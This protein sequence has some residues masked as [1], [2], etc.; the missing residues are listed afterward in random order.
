MKYK[1][2]T[3]G[4]DQTTHSYTQGFTLENYQVCI[5]NMRRTPTKQGTS[6]ILDKIIFLYHLA[7][8]HRN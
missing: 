4:E 2:V 8:F 5:P 6:N 1:A 3:P 7:C